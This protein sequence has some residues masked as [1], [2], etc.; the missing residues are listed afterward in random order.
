MKRLFRAAIGVALLTGLGAVAQAGSDDDAIRAVVQSAYVEGVHAS[1]DAA[2]MRRGFHPDFRM[3]I[4][5][6]GAMQALSL[7]EWVK[8]IEKKKQETAETA[9]PQIKADFAGI[10][11]TGNAATVRL[12]LHRDGKLAFTDYLSLYRF[13][14]GWKIVSKTFQAHP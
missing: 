7:A 1:P 5:R 10:D 3:L 2:A 8:R 9:R 14:D 13:P 6:D 11:V 12:Q 4:L